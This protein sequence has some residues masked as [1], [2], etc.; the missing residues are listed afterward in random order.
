[1][2][3]KQNR[4][5]L[6]RRCKSATITDMSKG[7]VAVDIDDVLAN[8]TE[9]LR[10]V[11]NKHLK[12]NLLPEHYQI[13]GDYWSHYE[14]VWK[15]HGLEKRISLSDIEPMMEVNQSHVYPY[16]GAFQT[17][18]FLSKYYELIVITSRPP[19]WRLATEQWLD[20]NFSGLFKEVLFTRNSKDSDHKS[21]GQLLV[22]HNAS[23]LIDDNVEHALSAR[24]KNIKVIL[25]GNYGWHHKAPVNMMRCKDWSAV[26]EY[27]GG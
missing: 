22:E 24:D 23:W 11:V 9:A 16:D 19:S 13:P 12:V 17:L 10:I 1:M 7:V 14:E 20:A 5:L 6:N 18:K 15:R 2:F 27:F 8:S 4:T 21:K 26:R 3:T 25:F